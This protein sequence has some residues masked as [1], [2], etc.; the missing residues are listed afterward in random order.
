MKNAYNIILLTIAI[1]CFISGI[2]LIC[3]F[4]IILS[5]IYPGIDIKML[6][7]NLFVH[8]LG[9]FAC[10][11]ICRRIIKVVFSKRKDN[12][13]NENQNVIT[14]AFNQ[15]RA[16]NIF[17]LLISILSIWAFTYACVFHKITYLSNTEL[18]WVTNR[19]DYEKMYFKSQW[20]EIDTILI[21]DINVRNSLFPI[22]FEYFNTGRTKLFGTAGLYF[23][24]KNKK[25]KKAG[26]CSFFVSKNFNSAPPSLSICIFDRYAHK[27]PLNATSIQIDSNI[28]KDIIFFSDSDFEDSR[29]RKDTTWHISSCAWS[30]Q[31]GL[32]Q[33]T[34]QDGTSFSRINLDQMQ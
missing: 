33:Y 2:L 34:F 32:V 30:K 13:I 8:G 27:S 9:L 21:G 4:L 3:D 17:K 14:K 18:M 10:L 6:F 16:V 5:S 11:Y 28:Y 25:Y 29:F 24:F 22:N 12:S 23:S 31:Y 26:V 19:S 7:F 15:I 1:I 20:G